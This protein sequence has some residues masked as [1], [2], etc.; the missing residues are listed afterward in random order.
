MKE[1][2]A[3]TK[4]TAGQQPELVKLRARVAELENQPTPVPMPA[5]PDPAET[6]QL[7]ARAA[8]LDEQGRNAE[9]RV[10]QLSSR[11]AEM[12]AQLR[13]TTDQLRLANKRVEDQPGQMQEQVQA[14]EEAHTPAC[15]EAAAP[16][17]EVEALGMHART[18]GSVG[19]MRRS[20][21]LS[22]ASSTRCVRR[23]V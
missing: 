13:L 18:R 11:V 22:G 15:N 3:T 9:G 21:S 19:R 20:R 12:E 7:R 16:Q 14:A 6:E 10:A 1:L 2:E 5:G 17:A 8:Q 4:S 23:P